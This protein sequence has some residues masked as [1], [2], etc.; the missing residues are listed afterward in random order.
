MIQRVYTRCVGCGRPTAV[1]V[2]VG[3]GERQPILVHCPNCG[4]AIRGTLTADQEQGVVTSVAL[5]H[6]VMLGS[7]LEDD[8]DLQFVT[9]HPDFPHDPN[10]T[11]ESP[12]LE[13]RMVFGDDFDKFMASLARFFRGVDELW[14]DVERAYGYYLRED[15]THF[16]ASMNNLLGQDWANPPTELDR[17]DRI[18]RLL[19]IILMPLAATASYP[20]MKEQVWASANVDIGAL[21]KFTQD[22]M[23]K[24]DIKAVQRRTFD[25]IRRMIEIR[26]AWRPA[27]GLAF[28]HESG[29]TLPD[30]W[31]LPG[32]N[33]HLLRDAYRQNFELACQGL[34]MLVARGVQEH[35]RRS[36]C[37]GDLRHRL[38]VWLGAVFREDLDAS[39]HRSAVQEQA[40]R[41][42]GAIPRRLPGGSRCV[43]RGL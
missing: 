18:H 36:A 24:A 12:F 8:P 21:R 23:N 7:D 26:D 35:P 42:Q 2:S 25:Q 17:H 5:D 15:W 31:R 22:P 9:T 39:S 29:M 1:R 40:R 28:L 13:A 37:E 4:A 43:G 38:L 19:S 27:L 3:Y 14:P 30:S 33:F 16:D 34:F 6:H 10:L 32:D 11:F 41:D 20:A